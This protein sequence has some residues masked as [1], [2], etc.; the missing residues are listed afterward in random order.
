[1]TPASQGRA[2]L[3][4]IALKQHIIWDQKE[5]QVCINFK[6]TINDTFFLFE[7]GTL[8]VIHSPGGISRIRLVPRSSSPDL[9]AEAGWGE[10][11]AVPVATCVA[12]V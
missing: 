12:T 3:Y 6:C 4:V 10:L 1:M 11:C 7:E 9:P 8:D 5:H 2:Q